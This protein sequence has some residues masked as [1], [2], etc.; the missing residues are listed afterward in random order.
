[1]RE[2]RLRWF[3]YVQRMP[4]DATM[5]KMI[6]YRLQALKLREEDLIKTARNDLNDLIVTDKVALHRAQWKCKIYV[7]DPVIWDY[8]LMINES[9]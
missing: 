4:I 3:D 9:A 1:M 2:N 6:M 5:R 8:G 7:P